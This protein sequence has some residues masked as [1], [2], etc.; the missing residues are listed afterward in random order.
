[1][2]NTKKKLSKKQ[3]I[4][5]AV[6]VI[7]I[8]G[9]A[10][11]AVLLHNPLKT[12]KDT[13]DL[14]YGQAI[15]T[16]AKTY[17]KKDVDKDIIKNT[18]VTYKANPVEGQDYDQIGEYVLTLKYGKKTAEV[19]VNVQDTTKPE[20]NATADAGIETIEGVELNFEELITASD[21][22]GAEVSFDTSG[23]DL[24]KAGTYTLKA[25]AKDGA[26]N[27][28]D[29]EIKIIVAAKPANMTG[30]SVTVDSKTGKVSVSAKTSSKSSGSSSSSSSGTSKKSS[31]SSGNSNTSQSKGSSSGY[32]PGS[33]HKYEESDWEEWNGSWD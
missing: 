13:F 23:V 4:T 5:I 3:K 20:F 15:S 12:K 21:L 33:G 24:T 25:T 31:G 19:T 32:I 29:K 18:K 6:A 22:S 28:A 16:E 7:V 27:E 2:E 8:A 17:L 10:V 1:M 30:S 14:E 26:G 11:A 9:A